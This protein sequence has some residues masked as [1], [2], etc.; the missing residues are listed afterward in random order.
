MTALSFVWVHPY[1]SRVDV[2]LR[3]LIILT[4]TLPLQVNCNTKME[5]IMK[6]NFRFLWAN[7]W[8]THISSQHNDCYEIHIMLDHLTVKTCLSNCIFS[9]TVVILY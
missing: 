6:M 1:L 2:T 7:K 3:C 8:V 5:I 9:Q 4:T